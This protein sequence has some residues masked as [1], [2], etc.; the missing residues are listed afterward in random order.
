ME[1]LSEEKRPMN[2]NIE[3]SK[4]SVYNSQSVVLNGETGKNSA[5]Y[6]SLK[7]SSQKAL[8]QA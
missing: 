5:D 6:G 4:E 2:V 7:T 3:K 1:A 8:A